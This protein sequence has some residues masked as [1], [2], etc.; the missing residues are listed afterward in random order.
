MNRDFCKFCNRQGL[1]IYPVRYAVACPRGA[2]AIPGLSG[3]F[4]IDAA[5]R[6]VASAK[7]CL[8]ALRAGYLYTYDEK[9]RRLKAYVATPAGHLCSFALE[10]M[11]PPAD[12]IRFNCIAPGEIV[13]SRCVDIA[14]TANNPAGNFWIGW[15]N[16]VWTPSLVKQ[17]GDAAW[18]AKHMQC[19]NI[20]AMLAGQA[21]HSEEFSHSFQ[22]IAHFG[23]D[24]EALKKAFAFSNTSI[25]NEKKQRETAKSMLQTMALR[26]P[27]HQGFI[28]AL[29]DPVGLT[30]DL[31]ELVLPTHDSGFDEEQYRGKL[32]ADLIQSIEGHV[33]A[34]AAQEIVFGDQVAEGAKHNEG[35]DVYGAFKAIGGMIKAGGKANYEKNR[36]REREKYGADQLGRQRAAADV[37]WKE[38]TEDLD[39]V[40]LEEFPD[41]YNAAIKD[42]E[43]LRQKLENAH[44]AW[45]VS[46]QLANWMAGVYDPCDIRSGYAYSEAMS[47]CIGKAVATKACSDQLRAWLEKGDPSDTKNP[48]GRSLLFNQ[49]AIIAAAHPHI[50]GSDVQTEQV[51][52]VYAAAIDKLRAHERLQLVD[53]LALTT[54]NIFIDALA[55]SAITTIKFLV[56]SH[57]RMIGRCT[58]RVGTAG[59]AQ[60][61]SQM[62][63]ALAAA[64]V[65]I[66]TGPH[67]TAMDAAA[68]ARRVLSNPA[69][70]NT[71][72]EINTMQIETDGHISPGTLQPIRIPGIGLLRRWLS[73]S[74]PDEFHMGVIGA[75]LQLVALGFITK[76][77][78]NNDRYSQTETRVKFLSAIIGTASTVVQIVAE[79]TIKIP[80]HP[81][82]QYMHSQWAL[83]IVKAKKIVVVARATGGIAGVVTSFFDLANAKKSFDEEKFLLGILYAANGMIGISM[84]LYGIFS[85]NPIFWEILIIYFCVGIIIGILNEAELKQWISRCYFGKNSSERY[86]DIEEE[87]LAFNSLAGG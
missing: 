9:R 36:Q 72:M 48:F 80:T 4:Q 58:L 22:K 77:L 6:D 17:I 7:Y 41:T 45:L 84:A 65:D 43:P 29:N 20:P 21:K 62:L 78:A 57:L 71:W 54:A 49:N 42:F 5:P 38:L 11:P 23:A 47:Q 37:A 85:S 76:D 14:H 12:L 74:I 31:S 32:V 60:L 87:L 53:R 39:Y 75:I 16:V 46:D 35:G 10:H 40:K 70:V 51:F 79:T 73:S 27:H 56:L 44:V 55:T 66:R 25:D 18:R 63:E 30:N 8:R 15:S 19:I 13:L 81:L 1:L 24:D 59:T 52:K 83:T 61:A 86:I 64:N 33:R 67:R 82:S 28:V 3:N 69:N 68:E 26:V 34:H 2:A 50:K